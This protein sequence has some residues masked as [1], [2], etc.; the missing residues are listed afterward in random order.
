[1]SL[2]ATLSVGIGWIL[3]VTIMMLALPLSGTIEY[4]ISEII[5]NTFV[6][7]FPGF[8]MFIVALILSLRDDSDEVFSQDLDTD[9][10][11]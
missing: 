10:D 3:G 11:N 5:G 1:M 7:G 9:S 4:E 8:V 6:F 2:L